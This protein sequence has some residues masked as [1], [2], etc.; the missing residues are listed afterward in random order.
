MRHPILAWLE[1]RQDEMLSL[2]GE[3]VALESPS[4]EKSA[5]DRLGRKLASELELSGAR[6]RVVEGEPFGDHLVAEVEGA[7]RGGAILLLGHMDTVWGMGALQE[8]PFRVE[9]GRAHGPGVFDMKAGL[10]QALYAL[11]AL[12]ETNSELS[13]RVTFLINSDEETG[14]SS[15]RELIETEARRSRAVFVLEPAL[16]PE[17]RIKTFRK[18]VGVFQ[19]RVSGKAAH[20]GLDPESGVSAIEELARQIQALHG[21]TDSA[22]GVTVNVGTVRGGTRSNVIA[23]DAQAEID[24]RISTLA[25]AE[26]MQSRILGLRPYL[27]GTQV[28]VTGGVDRPP[29][30][31]SP[32]VVA[33]YQTAVAL[34]RDLGFELGEGSA[35]GG[36]DGN[37]TAALGVPTLDGLGAVGDGA[38]AAREYTVIAEMPRRAALLAGLIETV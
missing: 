18:G 25:D 34:A 23:A 10:V 9:K 27:D 5:V 4:T 17:G 31:R 33:L 15:S 21:M 19:I 1:A 20:A 36:S 12:R 22:R 16:G 32:D 11:R 30:E 13:A 24:L 2:L 28:I 37:F 35:G 38:H 8:M 26:E 3:L 29:L 6:V 7:D 14:S